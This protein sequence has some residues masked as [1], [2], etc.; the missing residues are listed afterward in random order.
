M[1][2]LLSH[3][4]W[5]IGGLL[6]ALV[7]VLVLVQVRAS[8]SQVGSYVSVPF[9]ECSGEGWLNPDRVAGQ[10][11]SNQNAAGVAV[12]QK[13]NS[14]LAC[15]GLALD[16]G[17]LLD[18][19]LQLHVNLT[20]AVTTEAGE[21]NAE[22]DTVTIDKPPVTE[23]PELSQIDVV[24]SVEISL[25][26][27]QSWQ[28][29]SEFGSEQ[30][31]QDALNLKLPALSRDE[32]T[33]L[34]ARL[35][36]TQDPN[37]G[38]FLEF[39][40]MTLVYQIGQPANLN[41]IS[42][43]NQGELVLSA[44]GPTTLNAE[45]DTS[46]DNL[47]SGLAG[48]IG[49]GEE[50]EVDI[51]ASLENGEGVSQ[52][53]VVKEQWKGA[54]VNGNQTWSLAY[55]TPRNV[56]PGA[57]QLVTR[58]TTTDNEV[59]ESVED[60]LVGVL[61]LNFDKSTYYAGQDIKAMFSVL[62]ERG[63]SVCDANLE[64]IIS[65][66]NA[67]VKR[68]STAQQNIYVS[69]TCELYGAHIQADYLSSFS[70]EATGL[71]EVELVAS[72][73]EL[74]YR[75][76]DSIELNNNPEFV[77]ERTGPTRLFP[78]ESYPMQISVT[79]NHDFDGTIREIVP[80]NF[81]LIDEPDGR[82]YEV[83]E[84]GETK[85][86]TWQVQAKTGDELIFT[87]RF[88]APDIS[89]AFYT[90]GPLSLT[91]GDQVFSENRRWQLAGD[92]VG[93]MLLF[94]DGASAPS[95][96]TCVSCSGGDPFYQVF[97]R[98][99]ETYGGTGGA[100]TH[101]HTASGSVAATTS[102][103]IENQTGT[104]I[105]S[106]GH[107]HSFTPSIGSASNLPSYR[108]LKIIRADTA[109]EPATLPAG[110]IGLFDASVP[111]G[112][113]T[114]SAQNGFYP[115]GEGTAGT[116]GGSNTHT[117]SVTGT[118]GAGSGSTGA[119]TT[120]T[121]VS[122]AD[123][124]HTH[125]VSGN[126]P[127]ANH[128]PPYIEVIFGQLGSDSAPPD[129]LL[130]MWDDEVP[131]NWSRVS[132]A[133]GAFNQVFLKGASSYGATGGSSSH[134]HSNTTIVSSAPSATLNRRSGSANSSGTHTHQVSI[135]SFS[136][137]SHLPPYRDVV[138]GKRVPQSDVDL[139]AYRL[140]ANTDSADVGAALAAQNTAGTSPRQGLPFRL[141]L[142]LHISNAD[143][144]SGDKS[145]KLQFAQ[146]SGTCDTSFNGET[147]ADVATGGGAIRFY[148]NAS[149]N[150]GDNLTSNGND[151][152]HGGDS[153]VDQTYEEANNFT[154]TTATIGD[155]EDGL[156]DFALVD[157]SASAST[158]YCFRVVRSND[159]LLQNYSVIPEVI[160]DDGNGHMLLMYDGGS[161]PSGWSC[162]SCNP[163]DDLYQRFYRGDST[164]GGT[165]GSPNH[166]HT[167]SG[168]VAATAGLTLEDQAG[169]VISTGAH[170][171]SFSP[172]VGNSS[173]LPTYRQ[174]KI[175]RADTSGVP[176]TLPTGG[177]ALF[178][179]AVPT[180]W[181]RYSAQDGS[182]VYG[183]GT[184]GTTGGSNTHSHAVT[185]TTGAGS[186]STGA[187]TNGSQ[188]AAA[189]PAHTHTVSGNSGADNH[190]PPFR[191]TILGQLD[192]AAAAPQNI[193]TM[194]D[195]PPPGSWSNLST[196]GQPFH[197]RFIKPA[198][199]YGTTSGATTHSHSNVDIASSGP[200]ATLNRRSGSANA[201]GSHTHTVTISSFST[202]NSLPPYVNVIIAKMPNPNLAPD[203]PTNLTQIR[204]SD[205]T[206]LSVG[207][208]T[209]G[210]QIRFEADATD[211]DNPDDLQLCVEVEVV[212]TAFDNNDTACGSAVSYSGTAVS[213]TVN[214]TGLADNTNYHWQARIKDSGGAV[215][216][217]VSYGA[218]AE[219]ATD[220]SNDSTNPTATVY[221]GASEDVDIDINNG[222]LGT[223][224]A[225]WDGNDAESG[226]ALYEYSVGTT[227][228]GTE[229]LGWTSN[230]VSD[231]AAP[232]SL[233]LRTGQVYFFNVRISDN[234]DNQAVV[235]TDG[236]MVAPTISFSTSPGSVV[237]DNLNSS[238]GYTSSKTTTL[239]T[240]TNAYGGY[241]VRAFINQLPTSQN[242]DTIP[243]FTGGTYASPDAWLGGDT[244]YGYTSNDSLV[245]GANR[246]GATPCAG[247]GNPPCYAPFTTA[248][249]GDIVVD[250]TDPIQ[251]T[252]L[253]N[254]NFIVTHRVTTAATQTAGTYTTLVIYTI[255]ARY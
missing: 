11:D 31:K 111:G 58:L 128:E 104:V 103:T 41:V 27:G 143:L 224:S 246:F 180:G 55:E 250:H 13:P 33:Q 50:P 90:L 177:I 95:G 107:G 34:Q 230:G 217:W 4:R 198:A 102:Q 99:N 253:T 216:G 96:W 134:G 182:Y 113:S 151:P 171:H 97:P 195:G 73:G 249:P 247:G 19:Q 184:A 133:S 115:R 22:F 192:A 64:L 159:D 30:L 231:S 174:L 57:Y 23:I 18:A 48:Q 21:L 248:A 158:N 51:S 54:R 49:L 161:I 144:S 220:F 125:T 25:D 148:D 201:S 17:S 86:L 139:S 32:L 166:N 106:G 203:N 223:L 29:I 200:S 105:S 80:Q 92:A 87:Y 251:G 26:Q 210:G 131:S 209:N 205:D 88:D 46:G 89:P 227:A 241:V 178:D 252:P 124:A 145:F 108:Q 211:D 213:V 239:T 127:S 78:I 28:K 155:G 137:D 60:V 234:A 206:T 91:E 228:G 153:V 147:Y 5:I 123:P 232:G 118:T 129:G 146:R 79:F 255:T 154:N 244:G 119:R 12:W 120:G 188:V 65:L 229:I 225:N 202:E 172:T 8:T 94:W 168:S 36:V 56:K 204:T 237:F 45:V 122:A 7:L 183:N 84:T 156:W 6:L 59:L 93:R 238:N 208:W 163:G 176:S 16:E 189:D 226:I 72:T 15:H 83:E 193:I 199:T 215:S 233:T 69:D 117:N 20:S 187:R 169:A 9:A 63:A 170:T 126:S 66:N 71:Y 77:V 37:E 109:G 185:G 53:I 152:T 236:I 254:Q 40:S 68:L 191:E 173:N 43:Q 2:P 142:A 110:A 165:G 149:P 70:L 196:S 135:T 61:A 52:S 42:E 121:Q 81:K 10:S 179:A 240:S 39:D 3:R 1:A 24:A 164:Y 140:Y 98:G 175:I 190:E 243:L 14:G 74:N 136:N 38:Q 130:A 242:N 160:T 150:D 214:I 221:D 207:D 82:P 141:R 194:W 100:T 116:S 35:V 112:W 197:Q 67:V 101:G 62:D 212:G 181:T 222:S 245:D 167:A 157:N 114:Y 44:Q 219:S 235:S 186:G 162:V 218:N 85:V 76:I 132:G 138:I 47:F 75:M